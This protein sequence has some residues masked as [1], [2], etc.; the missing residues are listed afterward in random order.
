MGLLRVDLVLRTPNPD[1]P[2][3]V[4]HKTGSIEMANKEFHFTIRESTPHTLPMAR[5][6]EY[7]RQLAK[8]F[9]NEESVHFLRVEEGSADCA[10][11]V[12]EEKEPAIVDRVRAAS[13]GEGPKEAVDAHN[14]LW[15]DL[16]HDN[17]SAELE[18]PNGDI[19]LEFPAAVFDKTETF[20][21]FW[22]DGTLDGILVKIGGMDETVPVH[23]V[24]EGAHHTCNASRELARQLAPRLFGNP[25]RVYGRGKWFRNAVGKWEMKWF[26]I[27]RF[28]DLESTSLLETVSR[29]RSIQDNDLLRLEDPLEEMR[30]LRHG[31]E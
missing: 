9:G 7:L 16:V 18:L 23:L 24:D 22:Q 12:D 1:A 21:P 11:E 26:D 2:V 13:V 15:A 5:L 25:I 19:L 14:T 30:K 31:E 10:I 8:V 28:E 20:G 4:Y 3:E 27:F 29:L 17:V 6:A